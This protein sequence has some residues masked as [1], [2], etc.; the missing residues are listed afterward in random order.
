MC[1]H[2]IPEF[3]EQV[4]AKMLLYNKRKLNKN[5]I[6]GLTEAAVKRLKL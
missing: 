1:P 3:I 2:V 5:T 4:S 6:P